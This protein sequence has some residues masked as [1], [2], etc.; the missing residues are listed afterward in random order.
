MLFNCIFR[1]VFQD[2]ASRLGRPRDKTRFTPTSSVASVERCDTK[3]ESGIEMMATT[4]GAGSQSSGGVPS[5]FGGLT[6]SLT[7]PGMATA[8]AGGGGASATGKMSVYRQQLKENINM[9]L[10]KS[11]LDSSKTDNLKLKIP[12]L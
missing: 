9:L 3:S 1:F 7:S 6:R 12:L 11:G 10:Y 5:L 2:Y 4:T 8:A